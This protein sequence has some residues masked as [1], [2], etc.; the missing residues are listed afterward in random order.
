M[1]INSGQIVQRPDINID[2]QFFVPPDVIDVRQRN[3][4][5]GSAGETEVTTGTAEGDAETTIDEGT[6][7]AGPDIVDDT[8][9]TNEPTSK[10][11]VPTGVTVFSQRARTAPGGQIV[12]DVV[13]DVPDIPGV[14]QI[15]VRVAA[16]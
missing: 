9:T 5:D 11:P 13:F 12:I 2:P 16:A 10:L 8:T 4:S 6:I 3:D 14:S 15:D 1:V 7:D